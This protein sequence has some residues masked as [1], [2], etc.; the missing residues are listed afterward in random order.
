MVVALALAPGRVLEQEDDEYDGQDARKRRRPQAPLPRAA[1]LRHL[2]PHDVAH[3]AEKFQ[4]NVV[5]A[6]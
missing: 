6:K 2:G 1:Q 4:K 3:T 5:T